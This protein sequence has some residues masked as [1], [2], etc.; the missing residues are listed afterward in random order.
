MLV[1][2]TLKKKNPGL[3]QW[4][5]GKG[6]A[7]QCRRHGFDPRSGKISHAAKQLSPCATTTKPVLW[8]LGAA[9]IEP[10]CCS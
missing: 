6:S 7:C 9:T 10:Q 1:M 3:P 8:S 4:L 5:S 2:V